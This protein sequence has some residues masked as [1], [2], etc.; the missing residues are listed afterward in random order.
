MRFL[1]PSKA[2]SPINLTCLGIHNTS[3]E[4]QNDIDFSPII[5]NEEGKLISLR[6]EQFWKE[7]LEN[8]FI[9]SGRCKDS[10]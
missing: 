9:V 2:R 3:N 4:K 5:S 1:H 7:L 6:E 10:K 8:Y